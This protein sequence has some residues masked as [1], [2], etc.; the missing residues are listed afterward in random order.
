VGC[1]VVVPPPN[2]KYVRLNRSRSTNAMRSKP[3]A[4]E[5]VGPNAASS[6]QQQMAAE[7]AAALADELARNAQEAGGGRNVDPAN[8]SQRHSIAGKIGPPPSYDSHYDSH[9]FGNLERR[10]NTQTS[11]IRLSTDMQC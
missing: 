3:A 11:I 4:V 1:R 6:A 2:A 7:T 5:D 9:V 8:K 10:D